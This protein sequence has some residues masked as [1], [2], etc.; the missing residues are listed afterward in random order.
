MFI[1]F[2][3]LSKIKRANN[4]LEKNRAV[5]LNIDGYQR[6]MSAKCNREYKWRHIAQYT[7]LTE[8]ESTNILKISR[9]KLQKVKLSSSTKYHVNNISY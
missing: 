9:H 8:V 1:M 5:V 7:C 2:L 3:V 4:E 6:M